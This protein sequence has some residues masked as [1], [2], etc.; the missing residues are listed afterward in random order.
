MAGHCRVTLTAKGFVDPQ[1][2]VVALL[3]R[4]VHN[5]KGAIA[6]IE[7][8]LVVEART[9]TRCCFENLFLV[10]GL[11]SDGAA[12]AERMVE[13]DKAG[14]KGRIRFAFDTIYDSLSPEMQKRIQEIHER[15]NMNAKAIFIK[16]K[17]VA[18]LSAFNKTYAI[19]SQMSGD[20]AHPTLSALARHWEHKDE[21]TL[22]FDPDPS[23][24]EL[25]ETMHLACTALMGVMVV[26]SEM[27]KL[28]EAGKQLAVLHSDFLALSRSKWAE[29]GDGA[30]LS[31]KSEN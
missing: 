22:V 29:A 27:H 9:L 19:Y 8:G 24:D 16:P 1:I 5:F 13:D 17:E 15:T 23:E 14:K 26:V 4:S 30:Q 2:L 31:P 18:K 20:A 10:G 12:F 7:K 28:T 11:Q 6:L 3:C 25:N 21:A